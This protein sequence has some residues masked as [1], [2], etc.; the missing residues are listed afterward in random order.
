MII[1][2]GYEQQ[3][4][5][6]T[7]AMILR[8]E[9]GFQILSFAEPLYRMAFAATGKDSKLAAIPGH[10]EDFKRELHRFSVFASDD[11]PWVTGRAILQWLGTDVIRAGYRETWTS[12][13]SDKLR[14]NPGENYVI[15]DVRFENEAECLRDMAHELWVDCELVRIMR[16]IGGK[17]HGIGGHPS[18]LDGA[19]I[20]WD[21]IVEN[22]FDETYS[23]AIISLGR[24]LL[25]L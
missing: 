15:T 20:K 12:I 24:E 17:V 13:L 2:L 8:D 4:G 14:K 23:E 19:K 11:G 18:D 25:G 7:A 22:W 10:R 21:R 5:K 3:V 9:L 16:P 1:G 6:D